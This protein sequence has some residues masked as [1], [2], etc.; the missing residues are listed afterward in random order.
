LKL[1]GSESA[2]VAADQLMAALQEAR[3]AI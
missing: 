1:T 2:E 3:C